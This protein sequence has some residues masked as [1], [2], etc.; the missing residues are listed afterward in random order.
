MFKRRREANPLEQGRDL[1]VKHL[2]VKNP[3][4]GFLLADD[5]VLT[6]DNLVKLNEISPEFTI[7][8]DEGVLF[9]LQ[10]PEKKAIGYQ[11]KV[12][13]SDADL[14]KFFVNRG[15]AID[16][17][18]QLPNAIRVS[19]LIQFPKDFIIRVDFQDSIL[20]ISQI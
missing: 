18:G 16:L 11:K 6:K 3:D 17:N 7:S 12:H 8:Y 5:I 19:N 4:D 13:E 15:L 1:F 2:M 10:I 20:V 14:D 9:S